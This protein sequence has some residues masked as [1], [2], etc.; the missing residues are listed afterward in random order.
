MREAS[1]KARRKLKRA[2]RHEN[3]EDPTEADHRM[4]GEYKEARRNLSRALRKAK[5]VAWGEF[6]G[7]LN[8]NPWD[9][10]YQTIMGKLRRWTP[11]FTESLEKP[12]LDKVLG[13]LFPPP[14]GEADEWTE[15][16]LLEEGYK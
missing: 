6:V 2:R 10:P 8:E 16:P 3:P 5:A 15:P 9:R 4:I 1:T 12:V 14:M 13:G 7:T 11:P